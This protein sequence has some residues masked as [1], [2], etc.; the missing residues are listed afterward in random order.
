M[1]RTFLQTL[2]YQRPASH[3]EPYFTAVHRAMVDETCQACHG[4][5]RFGVDDKTFCGNSGCHGQKWPGLSVTG[6]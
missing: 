2:Y 6:G 5:I 4:E 3:A 1:P